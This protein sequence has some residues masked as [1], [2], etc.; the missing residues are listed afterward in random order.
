MFHEVSPQEALR[1]PVFHRGL[2]GT[3]GG[4]GKRRF[5]DLDGHGWQVN[6]EG[7]TCH[8]VGTRQP[9]VSRRYVDL[10]ETLRMIAF[11]QWGP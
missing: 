6:T 10:R 1:T 4:T 8:T 11:G 3:V 2:L 5:F 7:E 9:R